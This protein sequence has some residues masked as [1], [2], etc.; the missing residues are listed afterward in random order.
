[1]LLFSSLSCPCIQCDSPN[2]SF[3]GVPKAILEHKAAVRKVCVG[4][5]VGACVSALAMCAYNLFH[6]CMHVYMCVC[7]VVYIFFLCC[8]YVHM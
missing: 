5:C 3:V 1:M 4:A 8:I 7:M 6:I 2:C